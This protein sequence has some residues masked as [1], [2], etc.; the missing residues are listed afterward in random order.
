VTITSLSFGHP[1]RQGCGK[2][3]AKLRPAALV[4]CWSSLSKIITRHGMNLSGAAASL[5]GA[6]P[7]GRETWQIRHWP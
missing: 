2:A 1:D 7:K 6:M 3:L 4:L 5:I